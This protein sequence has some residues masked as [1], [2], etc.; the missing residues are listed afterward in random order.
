MLFDKTGTL[1][2]GNLS[3]RRELAFVEVQTTYSE[4]R[5][6]VS[7]STHPIAK[8]VGR[9][10][11]LKADGRLDADHP[12]VAGAIEAVPGQGVLGTIGGKRVVMAAQP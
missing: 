3:V 4:L 6:M 10:I 7:Q 8:A 5:A 11:E 12:E 1:T 2:E 9:Y